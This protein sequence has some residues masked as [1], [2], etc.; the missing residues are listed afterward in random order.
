MGKRGP[1]KT[2]TAI[3]KL[4]GSGLVPSRKGEPKPKKERPR[5]PL[6]I[7]RKARDKSNESRGRPDGDAMSNDKLPKAI[8]DS[9]RVDRE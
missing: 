2:P 5:C 4:R 3:L 9:R 6:W 7:R 1:G 8:G